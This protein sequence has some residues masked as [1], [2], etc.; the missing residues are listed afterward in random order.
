M[1]RASGKP[2]SWP[3]PAISFGCSYTKRREISAI[4]FIAELNFCRYSGIY[5]A[6]LMCDAMAVYLLDQ[7]FRLTFSAYRFSMD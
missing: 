2:L 6:G 4:R 1:L 7:E 3:P 5:F